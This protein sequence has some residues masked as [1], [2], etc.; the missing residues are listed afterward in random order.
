MFTQYGEHEYIQPD[1]GAASD[2]PARMLEI[3]STYLKVCELWN[4]SMMHKPRATAA[5]SATWTSN[6][7]SAFSAAACCSTRAPSCRLGRK[8]KNRV[9]FAVAQWIDASAPNNFLAFAN[10]A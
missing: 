3:K 9:R 2:E 1:G 6:P 5:S 8:T 7:V 10:Q 4:Q